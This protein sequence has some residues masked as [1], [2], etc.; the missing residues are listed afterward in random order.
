MKE[1]AVPT[2][3]Q[4]FRTAMALVMRE[5]DGRAPGAGVAV[6]LAARLQEGHHER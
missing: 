3:G 1:L 6:R 2:P 4:R 5:L